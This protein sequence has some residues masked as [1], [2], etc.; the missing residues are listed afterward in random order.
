MVR[1]MKETDVDQ[2]V[3]IENVTFSDP[4][5]RKSFLDAVKSCDTLYLV[6]EREGKIAGYCG[7]WISFDNADLCNMAVASEYRQKGIGTRLLKEGMEILKQKKVENILLEVRQSN[8]NAQK[9]YEKLEFQTI[10]VRKGYYSHP[11]EDA[12]LMKKEWI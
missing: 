7:F 8:Q 11:K 1:T 10:G 4:W 2:V 6:E 9:L 5:S 12:I 3:S